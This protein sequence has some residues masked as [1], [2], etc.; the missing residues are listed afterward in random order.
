MVAES[1]MT[2]SQENRPQKCCG[3]RIAQ[4]IEKIASAWRT[5]LV[6]YNQ[7]AEQTGPGPI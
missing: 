6:L 1:D 7:K 5:V 3:G 2:C 4:Q